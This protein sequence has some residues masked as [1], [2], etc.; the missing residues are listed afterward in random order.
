MNRALL[1]VLAVAACGPSKV[2]SDQIACTTR[3]G[4]QV[5]KPV[6]DSWDCPAVQAA[7]N[8]I[9]RAFSTLSSADGRFAEAP[10]RLKGWQVHVVPAKAWTSE[11]GVRVAGE[12]YCP[13]FT[14]CI[15][16]DRPPDGSL[17]HELAHAV[18]YCEPV[19][20]PPNLKDPQHSNWG[21]IYAALADQQ[22]PP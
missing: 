17:G 8:S 12:T 20:Y 9:L 19:M 5:L 7:E 16:N 18:Q 2:P 11:V 10:E 22:I 21:P 6:P 3:A 1:I 15:N 14:V 4:L 13:T